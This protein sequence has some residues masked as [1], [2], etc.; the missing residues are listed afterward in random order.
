MNVETA[1]AAIPL[2][3]SDAEQDD[4]YVSAV[5]DT[6]KSLVKVALKT[7]DYKDMV[8]I[9]SKLAENFQDVIACFAL[10]MTEKF[11]VKDDRSTLVDMEWYILRVVT[12]IIDKQNVDLYHVAVDVMSTMALIHI[13]EPMWEVIYDLCNIY[14]NSDHPRAIHFTKF[15]E[16]LHPC[17]VTDTDCFVEEPARLQAFIDVCQVTLDDDEEEESNLVYA[18]KLMESLILQCGHLHIKEAVPK[19]MRIVVQRLMNPQGPEMD[20]L[21]QMLIMVVF[22]AIYICKE[23][24]ISVLREIMEIQN[25]LDYFCCELLSV[26]KELTGVHDRKLPLILICEFLSMPAEQRPAVINDDPGKVIKMSISLFRGL[27]RVV[28]SREHKR[29][30]DRGIEM[31]FDERADAELNIDLRGLSVMELIDDD[32]SGEGGCPELYRTMFDLVDV[33]GVFVRF[34][35]TMEALE[36]SDRELMCRMLMNLTSKEMQSLRILLKLCE[37]YERT[38]H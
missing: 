19:M 26:H 5:K 34:K 31:E 22:A 27:Q 38:G 23:V 12:Y 16:V 10:E 35:K 6:V 28:Q 11:A 32:R 13:T 7:A 9:V 14:L 30:V 37:R 18:A 33:G 3:R 8:G 15:I 17:L 2:V 25:P 21:R 36:R 20:E 1:P 4:P 24:T 29:N